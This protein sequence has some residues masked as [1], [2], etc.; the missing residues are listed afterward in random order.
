MGGIQLAKFNNGQFSVQLCGAQIYVLGALA[1]KTCMVDLGEH[2]AQ[3][4]VPVKQS[5]SVQSCHS[6]QDS[7]TT[8]QPLFYQAVT[9]SE[10]FLRNPQ[11]YSGCTD[12]ALKN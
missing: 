4:S 7:R 5:V 11:V 10:S 8:T 9:A 2:E 12:L 6:S 3:T 1:F